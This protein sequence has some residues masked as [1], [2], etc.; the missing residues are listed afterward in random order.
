M[1]TI[2]T[3]VDDYSS[4][5]IIETLVSQQPILLLEGYDPSYKFLIDNW[6]HICKYYKTIPQKLILLNFAYVDVVEPEISTLMVKGIDTLSKRGYCI[7]RMIEFQEC[8][9]KCGRAVV[10]KQ[11]FGDMRLLWK[12][13]P[14][15]WN[16][17]C[18][19]C[20]EKDDRGNLLA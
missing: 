12:F 18:S 11:M 2:H 7:R 15:A 1:T 16:A 4:E 19:A 14:H 6:N 13:L 9:D 10:S 17:R 20:L 8:A 3:N 5:Q